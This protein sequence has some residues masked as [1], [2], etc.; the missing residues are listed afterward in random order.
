M[1]KQL[2]YFILSFLIVLSFT[3]ESLPAKIN[4]SKILSMLDEALKK[5]PDKLEEIPDTVGRISIYAIRIDK[6]NISKAMFRQIQGKIE[7]KLLEIK[8]PVLVY[9]P[10]VKPIKIVAK[11]GN[12][13]FSSVLQ[14]TPEIKKVSGDLN[15]DGFLEGAIYI[16]SKELYLNL[17]IFDVKSMKIVWSQT[18]DN[19]DSS[20]I[21]LPRTTGV[22]YGFGMA[23]IYLS[24]VSVSGIKI[25]E[26]A[27]Y[28]KGNFRISQKLT[29]DIRTRVT[30]SCSLLYLGSGIKSGT[31]TFLSASSGRGAIGFSACVGLRIP[32]IPVKTE[33]K[34]PDRDWLAAEVKAGKLWGSKS[35]GT[36]ILGFNL[37]C[38]VTKNLTVALGLSY[39]GTQTVE[40]TSGGSV[41][42][43]GLYYE[44]S[45]LQFNYRP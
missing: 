1:K 44:I 5:L 36:S 42:A 28:Y 37:E 33:V 40:Y 17:R 19:S 20:K 26:F 15:I 3:I 29:Q 25:P 38:D 13:S 22:D 30:I 4:D 41:K 45:L 16:T 12:V 21:A 14:T 7:S 34:F 35:F 18:L 6:K 8:K 23:G 2:K 32:I 27:N 31:K 9:T 39:A 11:E 10:E 43:G 24:G